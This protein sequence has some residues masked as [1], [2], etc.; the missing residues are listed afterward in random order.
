MIEILKGTVTPKDWAAVGVMVGIMVALV[1]IYVLFVHKHQ[2]E[3]LARVEAQTQAIQSDLAEARDRKKG[4]A[5]FAKRHGRFSNWCR[6]STSGFRPSAKS[7]TWCASSSPWP[8]TW[9]SP[10]R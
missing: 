3:A 7:P 8:T 6:I 2:T 10:I 9:G 1:A 5:N 4:L